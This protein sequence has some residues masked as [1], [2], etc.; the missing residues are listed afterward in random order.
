M[1]WFKSREQKEQEAYNRGWRYAAGELLR[2]PDGGAHLDAETVPG[3]KDRSSLAFARG[4]LD[5][6]TE[7]KR[8][9]RY[10]KNPSECEGISALYTAEGSVRR[11]EPVSSRNSESKYGYADLG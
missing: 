10:P 7:H 8:W 2:S 1:L 9:I 3:R 4:M 6:L 5:A 11:Y